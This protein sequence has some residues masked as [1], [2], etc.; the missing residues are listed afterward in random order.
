MK[1]PQNNY[2]KNT[3]KV[4][5]IY[6]NI[7]IIEISMKKQQKKK[8]RSTNLKKYTKKEVKVHCR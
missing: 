1:K 4:K 8:N 7:R 3:M 2:T 5:H 6:R